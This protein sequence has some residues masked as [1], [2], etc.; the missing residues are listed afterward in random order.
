MVSLQFRALLLWVKFLGKKYFFSSLRLFGNPAK[1]PGLHAFNL[2]TQLVQGFLLER[3]QK[4]H[5]VWHFGHRNA[6]LLPMRSLFIFLT[7]LTGWGTKELWEGSLDN[8]YDC[9]R[10]KKF[11]ARSE[12]ET[13]EL[14]R[15]DFRE[16][17]LPTWKL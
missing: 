12:K 11:Q 6:I 16:K 5:W 7:G 3:N 2:G 9:F 17:K 15:A 14:N 4:N 13:A 8:W 10:I 1:D